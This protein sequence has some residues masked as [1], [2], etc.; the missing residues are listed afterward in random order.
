MTT[1]T[2]LSDVLALST[3]QVR[4]LEGE[5]LR[6]AVLLC[7]GFVEVPGLP[8]E[9]AMYNPVTNDADTMGLIRE[10]QKRFVICNMSLSQNSNFLEFGWHEGN[11]AYAKTIG[12]A[13]CRAFVLAVMADKKAEVAE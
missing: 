10:G 2:T 12:E 3:E 1:L 5:Q 7:L 6:R 9:R 11:G 4:L 13:A 8:L